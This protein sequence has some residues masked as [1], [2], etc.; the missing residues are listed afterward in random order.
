MSFGR[1][2]NLDEPRWSQQT[3]WGRVWHFFHVANPFN[4]CHTPEEFE[5]AKNVVERYRKGE[6]LSHLSEDELWKAKHLYDSA[7]HPQTGKMIHPLGRMSA[8][9]PIN[10]VVVGGMLSFYRS[11]YAVIFW[12]WVNQTFNAFVNYSNRSSGGYI[13]PLQLGVSYVFGCGGGIAVSASLRHMLTQTGKLFPLLSRFIPFAGMAAANCVNVSL[14]RLQEMV[15]G[16]PVF[17]SNGTRI[18][19]STTAG[20]MAV[21]QVIVSRVVNAAPPLLIPPV[22]MNR[23]EVTLPVLFRYPKLRFPMQ[24]GVIGL[25]LFASTP[26]TCAIFPQKVEVSTT[27]LEKEIQEKAK[28][29]AGS[30]DVLYY[31]KGL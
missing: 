2:V 14:M 10:L 21:G 28:V 8:Q 30:P 29:K 12:Q 27:S 13:S 9:V 5:R 25:T 3:Y 31:N 11:T 7:F 16:I 1:K 17:D 23:L 18:G 26:M 19:L 22:I 15:Q 6:N 20:S 24:L 4:L